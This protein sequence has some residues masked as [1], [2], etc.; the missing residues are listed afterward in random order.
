MPNVITHVSNTALR[1]T[2]YAAMESERPFAIVRDPF[3][4][5]TGR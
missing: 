1:V 2:I 3:A 4:R 5:A